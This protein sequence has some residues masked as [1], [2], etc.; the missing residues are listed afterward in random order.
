MSETA[1]TQ[2]EYTSDDFSQGG[3]IL[4]FFIEEQIYG[5]QIDYVAD[6]IEI[7]PITIVPKVP[8]YIKGVINLRGKVIPVMSLKERFGKE[9]TPYDSR[10]CIIVAEYDEVSVGMIIDRIS[11]VVSVDAEKVTTPPMYKSVNVNKFINYIV[12]DKEDVTLILDCKKI[13][14]E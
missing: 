14:F 6:I 5:I 7:Q 9:Q 2:T 12:N 4:T 1:L 13:I 3:K 11:E 10:T 8:S